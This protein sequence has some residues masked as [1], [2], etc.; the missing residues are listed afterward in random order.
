MQA[1]D[2]HKLLQ[3]SF[4]PTPLHRYGLP[5]RNHNGSPKRFRIQ[6]SRGLNHTRLYST[7]PGQLSRRVMFVYLKDIPLKIRSLK[8]NRKKTRNWDKVRKI[9]G[10]PVLIFCK[11][12]EKKLRD[13]IG[14]N[15]VRNQP[16]RSIVT[17]ITMM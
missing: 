1:N 14:S 7:V 12:E 16:S 9:L 8:R 5:G 13:N 11:M 4:P 3:P 6:E 17:K 2:V 10:C 15:K